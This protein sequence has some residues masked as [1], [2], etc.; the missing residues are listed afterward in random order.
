M[1]IYQEYFGVIKFF[2][3]FVNIGIREDPPSRLNTLNMAVHGFKKIPMGKQARKKIIKIPKK[4][5]LGGMT[6]L[7]TLI[8][9]K[10]SKSVKMTTLYH[11]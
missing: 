4:V 6:P 1:C 2:K 3:I 5:V 9:P 8:D 11:E 10:W 7:S